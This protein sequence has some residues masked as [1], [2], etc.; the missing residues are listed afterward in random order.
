ML[1][2]DTARMWYF[3]NDFKSILRSLRASCTRA[4]SRADLMPARASARAAD[5]DIR[6]D[7]FLSMPSSAFNVE[8]QNNQVNRVPPL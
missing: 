3:H 6:H 4:A 5:V 8:Q 1:D 2:T 7:H